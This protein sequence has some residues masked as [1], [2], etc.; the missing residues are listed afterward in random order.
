MRVTR[1]AQLAS[2]LRSFPKIII[3]EGRALNLLVSPT[4]STGVERRPR[5]ATVPASK[6]C[7]GPC[8]RTLPVSSFDTARS[9]KDGRRSDC[10]DCRRERRGPRG[11]EAQQAR[12]LSQ[13][14]SPIE[15]EYEQSDKR[16]YWV[17]CPHC[18]EYQVLQWKNEAGDYCIKW[19]GDDVENAFYVCQVSGCAIEHEHKAEMLAK[20]EW[21][22]EKPFAGRAGFWI[23]EAY[24]PF[25]TWGQST[26]RRAAEVFGAL[27][28]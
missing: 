23:W 1:D 7:S 13:R 17:P 8:G 9:R 11:R 12:A 3:K 25:V 27:I 6:K 15:W 14:Y 16:K 4:Q 20:G 2:R 24:S 21:R 22:A 10:K 19:D 28:S 5:R 18:D 26:N